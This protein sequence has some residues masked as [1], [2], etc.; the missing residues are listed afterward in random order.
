MRRQ[1]PPFRPPEAC[2]IRIS[3]PV[4]PALRLLVGLE[5]WTRPW[6]FIVYWRNDTEWEFKG[7]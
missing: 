5:W 6:V 3:M 1:L 2:H 4:D 7:I